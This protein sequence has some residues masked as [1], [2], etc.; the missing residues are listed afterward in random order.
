VRS[1]VEDGRHMIEIAQEAHNQDG[2][3]SVV[4]SGIVELPVR[5]P[6]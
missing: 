2:E 4:G 1:F 6:A 3:L 5:Q